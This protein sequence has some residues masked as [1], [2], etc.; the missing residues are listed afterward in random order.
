MYRIK[1]TT[2]TTGNIQ[3]LRENNKIKKFLLYKTAKK[4]LNSLTGSRLA[5]NYEFE[6]VKC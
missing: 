1:V 4:E 3:T 5:E 2:I 6:I